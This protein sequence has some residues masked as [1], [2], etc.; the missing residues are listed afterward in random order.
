MLNNVQKSYSSYFFQEEGWEMEFPI[1]TSYFKIHFYQQFC[2]TRIKGLV[3]IC[4]NLHQTLFV[5]YEIMSYPTYEHLKKD[6]MNSMSRKSTNLFIPTCLTSHNFIP[7]L[8]FKPKS[9]QLNTGGKFFIHKAFQ[10]S[11][12]NLS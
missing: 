7:T 11:A 2:W 5:N 10:I 12:L 9:T 1:T 3:I 4:E 6:E 8:S